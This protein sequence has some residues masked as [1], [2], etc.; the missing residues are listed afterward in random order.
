MWP[1]GE[2][3]DPKVAVVTVLCGSWAR[4]DTCATRSRFRGLARA[5]LEAQ[6]FGLDGG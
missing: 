1:K 6:V 5:N 4:A 3:C 2:F